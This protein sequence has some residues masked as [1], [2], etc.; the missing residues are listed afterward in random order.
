[1]GLTSASEWGTLNDKALGG[2]QPRRRQT[3]LGSHR[4]GRE[5]DTGSCI[6]RLTL[7]SMIY[8][9]FEGYHGNSR[10][11]RGALVSLPPDPNRSVWD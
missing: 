2:W 4:H 3:V 7:A 1:M 9:A 11:T 8:N 6:R 10:V 5:Y